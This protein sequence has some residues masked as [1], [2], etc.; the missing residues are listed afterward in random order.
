MGESVGTASIDHESIDS[1]RERASI[2]IPREPASSTYQ[3]SLQLLTHALLALA[4]Q[5]SVQLLTYVQVL[6]MRAFAV[7]VMVATIDIA[8]PE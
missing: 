3:E 1:P 5:E 4:Y 7:Q 2:G 8:G 6:T